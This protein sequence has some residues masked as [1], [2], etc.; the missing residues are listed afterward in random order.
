LGIVFPKAVIEYADKA[1]AHSWRAFAFA[2]TT[3]PRIAWD[4]AGG[5][6]LAFIYGSDTDVPEQA[7]GLRP[8]R[9]PDT[10][11]LQLANAFMRVFDDDVC[12]APL[13]LRHDELWE[14][15]TLSRISRSIA[16]LTAFSTAPFLR[17]LSAFEAAAHLRYEGTPFHASAFMTK[18][19]KWIAEVAGPRF[20]PFKESIQFRQALLG[21]KWVRTIASGADVGLVG[22]GHTGAIIGVV[23]VP[24]PK[25]STSILVFPSELRPASGLVRPGTMAFVA[26]ENGDLYVVLPSG[27][28]F[29][30]SQGSWQYLN[31]AAFQA[32]LSAHVSEQ[33]ARAVLQLAVDLSFAP[34]GALLC[35][36]TTTSIAELVPDHLNPRRP[37]HSLRQA[38]T[39]ISFDSPEQVSALRAI[40]GADGAVVIRSD[41]RVVDAACMIGEPTDAALKSSGI[42]SLR[43]FEGA[44]STAAWNASVYGIAIKVSDDGPISLFHKG[45]LLGQIG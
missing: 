18:Q 3:K 9:T 17:W 30:K 20:I 24:R 33:I 7:I 6:V 35:L 12:N 23:V 32:L 40:A 10:V 1:T 41:G 38:A 29:V 31:Y 14:T 45:Q 16:R 13:M 44:R 8:L 39:N 26:A 43:R 21:E 25:Q 37:N 28:V 19:R 42:S 5:R 34:H 36:P 11:D 22:L 27:A 15:L 4:A 2:N